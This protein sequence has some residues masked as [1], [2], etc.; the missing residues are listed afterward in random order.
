MISDILT[1][2]LFEKSRLG[3]YLIYYDSQVAMGAFD[4]TRPAVAAGALGIMWRAIDESTKY[5]LERKTFGIPIAGHQLAFSFV[6]M[7]VK[8]KQRWKFFIFILC[9]FLDNVLFV[10]KFQNIHFLLLQAVQFMLADMAVNLELS[11][12]ITYKAAVDADNGIKRWDSQLVI[13]FS[14]N[15]YL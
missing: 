4:Q 7:L 8:N 1:Q 6:Y 12:L 10:S 9:W 14:E 11:R 2:S 13:Q 15:I 5:S 3:I